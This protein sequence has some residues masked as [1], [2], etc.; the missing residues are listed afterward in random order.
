MDGVSFSMALR[1]F[2]S[3]DGLLGCSTFVIFQGD[4]LHPWCWKV[5]HLRVQILLVS[6]SASGK[7]NP[8]LS[9]K[10][11]ASGVKP[12]NPHWAKHLTISYCM[13]ICF[14]PKSAPQS[15]IA[16]PNRLPIEMATNW[17]GPCLIS[18]KPKYDSAVCYHTNYSPGISIS[19][20]Q[21]LS[22]TK[23]SWRVE[24]TNC[25]NLVKLATK[26]G[27]LLGATFR[28]HNPSAELSPPP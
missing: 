11:L 24:F 27:V 17:G 20:P 9:D 21:K 19:Y 23:W 5:D 7:F 26:N 15:P 25:L 13:A 4:V 16:S 28:C 18:G 1:G 10:Y 3:S 6:W 14:S 2:P 22:I 8:T 12:S